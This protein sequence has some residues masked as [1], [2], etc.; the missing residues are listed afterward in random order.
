M[1][2][3]QTVYVVEDDPGVRK[4]TVWMLESN[5]LEFEAYDSG[6]TFLKEVKLNGPSCLILDMHLPGTGRLDVLRAIKTRR[7]LHMP[8]IMMTGSGNVGLA[9]ECMKLGAEDFLEKPVNHE[10]LLTRVRD[11]LAQDLTRRVQL[12][13]ETT[14]R[15]RVAQLTDRERE[16][17]QLLCEGKSSKEMAAQLSIS[18]KTV[19]IHRWHLM[20]KMQAGNATEAVNLAYRAN[21]ISG[22]VLV[23][24]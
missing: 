6:E 5:G 1:I 22:S 24:R 16:V 18:I 4:S 8:V 7:E 11:G 19:S 17:L 15:R 14:L 21:V 13:Q 12:E 20:K 10:T 23:A 2:M 9:V 3:R